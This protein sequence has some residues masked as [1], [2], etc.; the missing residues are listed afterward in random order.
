LRPPI[1]LE[2]ILRPSGAASKRPSRA[3]S[4][5]VADSSV[6]ELVSQLANIKLTVD[7]NN[8]TPQ[9]Q[10]ALLKVRYEDFL[11]ETLG[12]LNLNSGFMPPVDPVFSYD[13]HWLEISTLS[14]RR[15]AAAAQAAQD[16]SNFITML[17]MRE[18]FDLAMRVEVI[19]KSCVDL[20]VDAAC[21]HQLVHDTKNEP[22]MKKQYLN[23]GG[24]F[25]N[26]LQHSAL[27]GTADALDIQKNLVFLC[28]WIPEVDDSKEQAEHGWKHVQDSLD[29]Y[30][31]ECTS[32]YT[33]TTELRGF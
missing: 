14:L 8:K 19:E 33:M 4:K 28:H 16:A 25:F 11:A 9:E 2:L 12:K 31:K 32:K 20:Q 17:M 18:R 22:F 7:A 30:I 26:K 23:L 27:N 24:A 6:N 10:T 5:Y 3:V 21:F 15:T 29:D 1:D 13:N